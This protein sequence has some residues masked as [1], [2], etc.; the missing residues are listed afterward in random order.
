MKGT[1]NSAWVSHLPLSSWPAQQR[2]V[3]FSDPCFPFLIFF[4]GPCIMP[5]PVL[6]LHNRRCALKARPFE[7]LICGELPPDTRRPNASE[8]GT[9]ACTV[10]AG[11]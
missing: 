6:N 10:Q 1:D 11:H 7:P 4:G 5:G 8:V 2:G 9:I 3:S